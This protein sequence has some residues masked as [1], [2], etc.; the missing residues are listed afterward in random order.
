MTRG[1]LVCGLLVSATMAG[2]D[3]SLECSLSAS[4][5]VETRSCLADMEETTQ[6]ALSIVYEGARAAAQE[7][8]EVT[9]RSVAVPALEAS[10]TAWERYRDANCDF[11]GALFGGGS[12]TGIAIVSCRIELARARITDLSA[13]LH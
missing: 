7:L 1:P 11:A 8:D 3:P 5:Q 4:S 10:Q 6:A 2:A 9:E 12:G 13:R